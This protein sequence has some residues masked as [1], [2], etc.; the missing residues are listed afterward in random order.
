MLKKV[1]PCK[2]D[3][4]KK[5][6]THYSLM[7]Q[8][9]MR[10]MF[11]DDPER[12]SRYSLCCA[13]LFIDY[14]KHIIN[15]DTIRMLCAL[16][17][18]SGVPEARTQ[19]FR[20]EIIN[21]TEQRAVL[22]TALRNRDN[23]PVRVNG[24]DIMPGINQVLDRMK[25]FSDDVREG[26]WKGFT[27]ERITD[28]VSIGIGG[29]S[30]GPEMATRALTPYCSENIRTH[31]V[32]N[33]DASHLTETLKY[34]RAESTLFIISSKT[35]TT[36][37]TMT[38]ARSA[39]RWFLGTAAEKDITRHFV[40]VSTERDKVR[41]F[42]IADDAV[43]EFWE[44]V[45]GRYSLWSAIGLPVACAAGFD[46]FEEL[47]EGAFRMDMHFKNAPLHE[48]APVLLALLGIWYNNFF[49]AESLAILPYDQYLERFPAYLQQADM[50]SNGK[51]IDRAGR[52]VSYQTGPVIWGQPG[53]NGQH[54]FYQLIHQGTKLIPC[55]FLVSANSHNP[56][57][58][59]HRVLLSHF[60]AQTEALMRGRTREEV[61]KELGK[62]GLSSDRKALLAP[63][64][65]FEGNRPTTSIVFPK[66]TPAIL[67]A[68]IALYEHKIFTQGVI[69]NVFSFDQWGV[70]LGKKL[71]GTI[72]A[73]LS[74][75]RSK[76][77]HDSST[78]GLLAKIIEMRRQE[79]REA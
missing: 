16:A 43:F 61:L 42:G 7:R 3:I 40:A 17:E 45:G 64:K 51:S 50:E 76:K 26:N 23:M 70:E 18:F 4:W 24:R 6:E 48:N 15:D 59:H 77:G 27:G 37:E 52:R 11:R 5:L 65:V 31:F 58:G 38:N 56:V 69:W 21:E 32:S 75:G 30:L 78:R 49:G 34:C 19:M 25:G 55:D 12:F 53:T 68:L 35:F 20:G 14:S 13:D 28:I 22:H 36:Q 79:K 33:V 2:S 10:D 47:R 46:R 60:L 1:N 39:R 57:E 67:G 72:E 66:M 71:A 62:E 8:V 73:E 44:W 74:A 54:A 9:H 29:S 63:F 41:E